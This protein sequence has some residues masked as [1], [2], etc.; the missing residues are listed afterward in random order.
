MQVRGR[1]FRRPEEKEH[2]GGLV[3]EGNK[4]GPWRKD[5]II[6]VARRVMA[7]WARYAEMQARMI[8]FPKISVKFKSN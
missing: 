5:G 6:S 7:F 4:A 1:C 8:T 3:N 2:T